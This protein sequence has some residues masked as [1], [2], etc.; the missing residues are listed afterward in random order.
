VLAQELRK[1]TIERILGK[2]DVELGLQALLGTQ[3][4]SRR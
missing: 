1:G 4:P 2:T 3:M